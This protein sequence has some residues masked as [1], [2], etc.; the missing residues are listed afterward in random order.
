MPGIGIILNPYSKKH[1]KD[2]D[3]LQRLSFI[4]GDKGSCKETSDLGDLRRVA[5]EFK[6]RGIEIL[7][8]GGGDGT[9]HVVLSTLIKVYGE[10][11]L[12]KITFLKGGTLNTLATACGIKGTPEKIISNLI[13]KYHEE[14]PFEIKEM[15]IMEINGSYGFIFGMGVIERFMRNYYEGAPSPARAA[16]CLA[17]SIGSALFNTAFSRGLF[18]R[19]EAKVTVDGQHWP[20]KNYSA[21]YAGAVDRLGL[22][23]R[24]F[25]Y[26]EVP[27][28]FHGIGFS[29]PPRNILRHVPRMVAG[30]APRS[31][32]LLE[33]PASQMRIE[34]EEP[35]PYTIDGDMLP[36]VRDF[37]IQTGP[38]LQIIVS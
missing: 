17:R 4:V 26:S 9:I 20:F 10:K 30:K 33:Q 12:P 29:T 11:P 19:F 18:E 3:R 15:D 16:W 28:K 37:K 34:L 38:C 7:G 21:L 14:K 27:G 8:I 22:G 25:H 24:V 1:K 5:E 23:A 36:A 6:T 13:Y 32:D 31:D 35:I 2:P